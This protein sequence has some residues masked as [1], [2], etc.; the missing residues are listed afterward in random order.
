MKREP[1]KTLSGCIQQ[2]II[3]DKL[4]EGLLRVRVFD[5]WESVVFAMTSRFLTKEQASTLTISKFYKDK[6]LTCKLNSS[7]V[8]SQ[9]T[10]ARPQIVKQMNTLLKGNYISQIIIS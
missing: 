3:E 1:I 6:I 9:L 4:D 2:I 8:R 5:A 7:V 10:M